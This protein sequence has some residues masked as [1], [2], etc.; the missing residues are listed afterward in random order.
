MTGYKAYQG[1]QVQGSGPLGLVLLTYEALY[2]ALGRADQAI[3]AG[4]LNAEA[5]NTSRALEAI[6]ELSTSLNMEEGGEIAKNLASIYN[7]MFKRLTEDMCSSSAEH[8]KEVMGLV[9]TLREGWQQLARDH[10]KEIA[11]H[12]NGTASRS[13]PAANHDSVPQMTANYTG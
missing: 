3:I 12:A 5:E 11:A 13:Q 7:Y 10:Q 9:Q 6:V 1:N 8:I 4:D 2:K